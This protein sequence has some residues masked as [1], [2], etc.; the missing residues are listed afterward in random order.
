M[1]PSGRLRHRAD[2]C[3][4]GVRRCCEHVDRPY[5]SLGLGCRV[6]LSGVCGP[7]CGQT[8]SNTLINIDRVAL[9]NPDGIPTSGGYLF[10]L[11]P[12]VGHLFMGVQIASD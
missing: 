11:V 12:P 3:D 9:I 8:G 7:R 6:W 2:C 1:A 10:V 4:A 5:D